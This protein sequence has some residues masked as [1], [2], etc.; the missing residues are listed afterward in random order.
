MNRFLTRYK[1]VDLGIT[2]PPAN[3]PAGIA[4]DSTNAL[5]QE[6]KRALHANF[7]SLAP[8]IAFNRTPPKSEQLS[9]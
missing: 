7:D 9:S 6:E 1:I 2:R 5:S 8:V 3:D 4:I